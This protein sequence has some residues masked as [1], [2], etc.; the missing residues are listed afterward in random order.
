MRDKEHPGIPATA[1]SS[2]AL[3]V[4]R[5]GVT[6]ILPSGSGNL[7]FCMDSPNPTKGMV[8]PNGHIIKAGNDGPDTPSALVGERI[9]RPLFG[10]ETIPY[11]VVD[12]FH[13]GVYTVDKS[14]PEIKR[15]LEEPWSGAVL[16]KKSGF[17]LKGPTDS[18]P[19]TK[20]AR[21][22]PKERMRKKINFVRNQLGENAV[23]GH[24]NV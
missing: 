3:K 10:S 21:A 9:S 13:G 7:G 24:S 14:D 19:S 16:F 5:G 20:V 4:G 6:Y 2:A 11:D 8:H 23:M 12:D 15:M 1:R 18:S 17:A 22:L